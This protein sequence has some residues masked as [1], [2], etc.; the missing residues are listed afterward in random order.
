MP[1]VLP[2]MRKVRYD[3]LHS[4]NDIWIVSYFDKCCTTI[5]MHAPITELQMIAAEL[6]N[7]YKDYHDQ[8]IAIE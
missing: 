5:G 8:S 3:Y 1:V 4:M 7:P 2:A 6:G